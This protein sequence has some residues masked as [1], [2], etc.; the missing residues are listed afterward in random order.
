ML[1]GP[2]N[3]LFTFNEIKNYFNFSFSSSQKDLS[4]L[5][6]KSIDGLI[7][8]EQFADNKE[9]KKLLDIAD[10]FKVLATNKSKSNHKNFDYLL[11]LPTTIKEINSLVE[12]SA[13]K[14]K[15]NENS[16]IKIKS[17]LLNKNEKKL[18]KSNNFIILTEK[19]IQ[20][21]ELFLKNSKPISKNDILNQ[22]WHYSSDADTHT[23][24][25]HIYRLRKKINDKFSDE[26]F[27]LNDK[28]GYHIWKKE[29]KLLLI[30][31][32]QNIEREL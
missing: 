6:L 3:F 19:E 27:I 25:T 7:C 26:K 14:K 4:Y 2:D 23:V 24:E 29:T 18:V 22:V 12:S 8:H 28:K 11:K 9:I 30:Y 17:Y 21:L 20:L 16:S 13:I 1:I 5:S 10:C 15:Y 31:F 32:P